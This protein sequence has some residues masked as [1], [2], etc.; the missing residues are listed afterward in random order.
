M[1]KLNQRGFVTQLILLL[2]LAGG[3]IAGVYLVQSRTNLLPKA[4]G[5]TPSVPESSFTLDAPKGVAPGSQFKV[6]VFVRS[7]ID[8]ANLFSVK[9][10]FPTDLLEVK[11]IQVNDLKEV[12][13][14]SRPACLDAKPRSC[15]VP[16][17][18]EGWCPE[19]SISSFIKNW[20]E[21]TFDNNAGTISL[22]GG[23]PNPGYQSKK[24]NPPRVMAVIIFSSKKAGKAAI[25][26]AGG[27]A[28]Y[29]NTD[30]LDILATKREAEIQVSSEV[31]LPV[32]TC[33]P[34]PACLD[35]K[36]ACQM[37]EPVEGWCSVSSPGPS[38]K[39]GDVNGDGKISLIDMS[40]L[41]SKWGK[42]GKEVGRADLNGDKVVNTMDYS[43]MIKILIQNGII[44][45]INDL[46][47][48]MRAPAA[49]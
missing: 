6:Q 27:T 7:D 38:Q 26:F 28:M 15:D 35:A 8:A 33:K 12:T 39:Q 31:P 20:V 42:K 17:P 13:C 37:P 49:R 46:P 23:V 40:A 34:R 48:S 30:N 19:P 16:E 43:L 9:L 21:K 2:L 22:V 3:A 36:P 32:P 24:N 41:L 14:Q 10:N 11:S 47:Q 25:S 18:A 44:S 29:R 45:G 5:G 1:P 4:G